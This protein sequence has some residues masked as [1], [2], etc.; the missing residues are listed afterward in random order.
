MPTESLSPVRTEL[1]L[2]AETIQK[3]QRDILAALSSQTIPKMTAPELIGLF[4]I[5]QPIAE[6]TDYPP[7]TK[8]YS[9]PSVRIVR[10]DVLTKDNET[11]RRYVRATR[12]YFDNI[13][14]RPKVRLSSN[15]NKTM[16]FFY[17]ISQS[18]TIS[19]ISDLLCLSV[20]KVL[21]KDPEEETLLKTIEVKFKK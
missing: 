21:D 4:R 2:T 13:W 15:R 5:S 20:G 10:V 11:L 1:R 12:L 19:S 6:V 17:S 14:V 16:T 3:I 8:G 9:L 18:D 7:N